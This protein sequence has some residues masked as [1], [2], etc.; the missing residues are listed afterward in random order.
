M[1]VSLK[2]IGLA[3]KLCGDTGVK[4]IVLISGETIGPPADR[5]YAVEPKEVEKIIPSHEYSFK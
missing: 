4:T 1:L 2:T 3:D 5:E